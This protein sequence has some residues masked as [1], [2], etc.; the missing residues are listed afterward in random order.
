MKQIYSIL[1]MAIIFLLAI[2]TTTFAQSYQAQVKVAYTKVYEEKKETSKILQ[3]LTKGQDLIVIAIKDQWCLITINKNRG[4]T[5]KSDL[6]IFYDKRVSGFG[7]ESLEEQKDNSKQIAP[8]PIAKK[9]NSPLRYGVKL[10]LAAGRLIGDYINEDNSKY[11][12]GLTLG[13]FMIYEI[14]KNIGFQ[15]EAIYVQKGGKGPIEGYDATIKLDYIEIPLMF[16]YQMEQM[17]SFFFNAGFAFG[18]NVNNALVTDSKTYV[19]KD[20]KN[21]DY[22]LVIG[23]GY[24]YRVPHFMPMQFDV[25]YYYGLTTVNDHT[26]PV[27]VKNTC[28]TFSIGVEL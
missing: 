11:R 8:E 9:N 27:D 2:S 1:T 22:G 20:I 14:T 12:Y 26:N 7:E 28:L 21:L 24:Q 5:L 3:T 16:R 10:G 15:A 4:W 17:N 18:V 19:F 25:R 23:A 13:G 6:E